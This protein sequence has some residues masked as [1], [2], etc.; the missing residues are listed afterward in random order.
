MICYSA[1]FSYCLVVDFV[2]VLVLSLSFSLLYCYLLNS[3]LL[4]GEL[5]VYL[6]CSYVRVL[7][8]MYCVLVGIWLF[9]FRLLFGFGCFGYLL[10]LVYLILFRWVACFGRFT[11]AGLS[12]WFV[13]AV[14]ICLIC[15][16][17]CV[18]C[19]LFINWIC[20]VRM[21]RFDLIFV[22]LLLFLQ[23]LLWVNYGC[24]L[25]VDLCLLF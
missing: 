13:I 10:L 11:L 2:I 24:L 7:C 1:G 12:C 9:V 25:F 16:N 18:V 22:D 19:V 14:R 5:F 4:L 8:C 6:L 17:Y 20:F 15:F 21:L 23:L 3:C